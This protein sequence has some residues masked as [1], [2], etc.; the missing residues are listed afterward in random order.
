MAAFSNEQMQQLN[1]LLG[2]AFSKALNDQLNKVL[3]RALDSHFG[4]F[5]QQMGNL[6]Q[7][8]EAINERQIRQDKR[9]AL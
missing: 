5:K 7:S 1:D 6:R 8:L 2:P 3:D 9:K 4:D